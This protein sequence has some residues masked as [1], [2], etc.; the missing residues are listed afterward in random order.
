MKVSLKWLNDYV[1]I[2]LTPEKLAEKLTMAG[3]EVEGIEQ[4]TAGFSG[5]VTA[6]IVSIKPHPGADKLKLCEVDK[7]D[8]V[9]EVVCGAPNVQVGQIAP[10]ATVGAKIPGGYEIK[11]ARIR[12]E[13]SYGMLCSEMELGLSDDHTGIM[14][15]PPGTPVGKDLSEILDL[16]DTVLDISITPNRGDCLSIIGIAR[17]VAALMRKKLRLPPIAVEEKGVHIGEVTSV[18]IID[19]DYCPRYCARIIKGVKIKPSPLWMRRRLEAVGLR[20][21]NN[22]VD[23]T[24]FV[25]MEMGQPLHAFDYRFLEEGRIVVRKAKAGETFVSLDGKERVLKE[26]TLLICDGVKPVAIAGIMGGLNSEVKDDTSTILLESAYFHPPAIRRAAKELGMSTDAAFRFERGVDPEGVVRALNRAAALMAD[27]GEGY[28]L[29]GYIDNYPRPLPAP[30]KISLRHSR[31]EEIMGAR[32]EAKEV[33]EI[34]SGLQ[35]E[36]VPEET[37]RGWF[38]TPPTYRTDIEREI[39]LIEEIARIKGYESIPVTMPRPTGEPGKRGE[40][41]RGK[42]LLYPVLQG[43]GLSEVITYSFLPVNFPAVLRVE[44]ER[45][46]R[47]AVRLRNPLSEDQ[48]LLRTNLTYSLLTTLRTNYRMGAGEVKIFEFGR[49]FFS[50]GEGRVPEEEPR[51][52]CLIWG[53][54]V[55]ESWHYPKEQVDFYDLKGVVENI[56]AALRLPEPVF[57]EGEGRP[58]LHPGRCASIFIK[59][60]MVGFLGEIHPEIMREMDIRGRAYVCE[61]NLSA[62]FGLWS[63]VHVSYREITRFPGSMRDAAFIVPREMAARKLLEVISRAEE[64]LLEKVSIFDVY[65]GPNL[66]SGT[67]SIGL[68]F[69]YRSPKRTLTDEEVTDV[70]GRLVAKI[71]GET[72]VTLRG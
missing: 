54:R 65:E 21:I 63:K 35:M 52:G 22:M 62:L 48:A 72:K 10:L 40:E 1:E 41:E 8:E 51:L 59:N 9:V 33:A 29:K 32:V 24:N 56:C 57:S 19:V 64:E 6:K 61:I 13:V 31:I 36:V 3:L 2:D 15:L 70:H 46:G 26:G 71:L 53:Q 43:A 28:V 12:G 50:Q 47:Q 44:N 5:V 55:A 14:V 30:R 69:Y 11:L 16:R 67:K 66:P 39:D 23:V 60:T 45:E 38:V 18:T 25:M 37:L 17:E 58:F 20:A 34:L 68:R 49:V 7:G 27:L 4:V 42:A